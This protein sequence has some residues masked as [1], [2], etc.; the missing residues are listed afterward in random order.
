MTLAVRLAAF[1]TRFLM[2]PEAGQTLI[3]Y[4]LMLALLAMAAVAALGVVG[5]D[6]R[7]L[8]T[9]EDTQFRNASTP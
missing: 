2:K 6:V 9:S 5:D 7:G 4:S 1:V 3:E 8:F